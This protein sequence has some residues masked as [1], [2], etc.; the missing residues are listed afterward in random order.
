MPALC[1]LL[2]SRRLLS[3]SAPVLADAAASMPALQVTAALKRKLVRIKGSYTGMATDATG[4]L[5]IT[6]TVTSFT[7]SGHFTG[8]FS[9]ITSKG[10]RGGVVTGSI[11]GNRH[12]TMVITGSNFTV[13]L[14]GKATKTGGGLAGNF[15]EV[16]SDGTTDAGT[17]VF[18][19]P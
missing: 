14:T 1:E 4:T 9:I 10:T 6:L 12:F 13:T 8:S 19:K 2:E 18:A 15:A 3:V 5:P 11:H 17:F 16:S 7:H